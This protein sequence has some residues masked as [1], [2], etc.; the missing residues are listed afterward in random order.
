MSVKFLDKPEE[1]RMV[2]EN[3]FLPPNVPL[4]DCG[5]CTVL[6]PNRGNGYLNAIPKIQSTF[7]AFSLSSSFSSTGNF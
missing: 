2:S 1:I 4:D 5:K 6:K 7:Y 3:F